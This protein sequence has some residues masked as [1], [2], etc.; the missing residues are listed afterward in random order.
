[1]AIKKTIIYEVLP[2]SEIVQTASAQFSWFHLVEIIYVT[3][4][5]ELP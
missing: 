3:S 4:L 2:D 5:K 1:M